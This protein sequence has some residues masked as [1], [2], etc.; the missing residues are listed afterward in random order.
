MELVVKKI[1]TQQ[2]N[3]LLHSKFLNYKQKTSVVKKNHC[4]KKSLE[5]TDKCTSYYILYILFKYIILQKTIQ[6][7]SN[8]R[9]NEESLSDLSLSF[10]VSLSL[11]VSFPLFLFLSLQLKWIKKNIVRE[12][13][14]SHLNILFYKKTLQISLSLSLCLS[15][16]FLSRI[17]LSPQGVFFKIFPEVI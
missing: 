16:M 9:E 2:R 8:V 12:N 5:K 13:E 14:E 15:S 11:H 3:N 10:L 17:S 1:S 7:R 4:K 6:N